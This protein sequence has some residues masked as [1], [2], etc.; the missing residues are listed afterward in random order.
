MDYVGSEPKAE[1]NK[2]KEELVL[3]WSVIKCPSHAPSKPE[4]LTSMPFEL[5]CQWLCPNESVDL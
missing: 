3:M 1:K 5:E 4:S 2:T